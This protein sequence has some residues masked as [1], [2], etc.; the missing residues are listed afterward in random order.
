MDC[1]IKSLWSFV[2]AHHISLCNTDQVLPHHQREGNTFIMELL[3]VSNRFSQMELIRINQ[4]RLALRAMTL[5]DITTGDGSHL[6][7]EAIQFLI[8]DRPLSKWDWPNDCPGHSDITLWHRALH[9]ISSE[10]YSLPFLDR[11]GKWIAE[12]H[13]QVWWFYF[14]DSR[15]LF[16][17]MIHTGTNL[18]QYQPGQLNPS[19]GRQFFLHR[20]LKKMTCNMPQPIGKANGY[21]V[22]APW[23]VLFHPLRLHMTWHLFSLKTRHIG[24]CLTA[25]SLLT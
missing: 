12:P 23:H 24:H 1:W 18:T 22:M 3:V 8:H 6:T 13:L 9:S 15:Q 7:R 20:R 5:A 16:I 2:S 14:P 11:L 17:A 21:D 19:I 4:C 25:S 10:T